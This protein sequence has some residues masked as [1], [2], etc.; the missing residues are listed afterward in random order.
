MGSESNKIIGY[1]KLVGNKIMKLEILESQDGYLL[2]MYDIQY[3]RMFCLKAKVLD[4]FS[5][6]NFE[7]KFA[8]GISI[9]DDTVSYNVGGLVEKDWRDDHEAS[10]YM[11]I[12]AAIGEGQYY[13]GF[14]YF[15]RDPWNYT[16]Y[17]IK[18]WGDG[19]HVWRYYFE[20]GHEK[21]KSYYLFQFPNNP[22]NKKDLQ[23]CLSAMSVA[24]VAISA[25]T[26]IG[27]TIGIGKYLT[28][29]Q[30]NIGISIT[31]K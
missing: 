29:H 16:G 27:R 12:E 3:A 11:D 24:A 5:I 7:E 19:S 6:H 1:K 26:F 8:S 31:P 13:P 4:I 9:R 23:T 10:Y 30:L 20:N 22:Q 18:A 21:S 25:V 14:G 28:G 15:G 17:I 2:G